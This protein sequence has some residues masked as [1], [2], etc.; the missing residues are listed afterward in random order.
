M[1]ECLFHAQPDAVA[2]HVTDRS[3]S[4]RRALMWLAIKT[5]WAWSKHS[6]IRSGKLISG[7]IISYDENRRYGIYN[8]Y[9]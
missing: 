3:F 1:E 9:V 6:A 2:N 7:Y 5:G 8:I 4:D